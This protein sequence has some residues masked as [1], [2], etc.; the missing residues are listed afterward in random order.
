M[1]TTTYTQTKTYA[2]HIAS[3]VAADL[4]RVQRIYQADR[5][6]D[7]EIN[8]Y[9][10]EI[11]LLLEK[12]YLGTVTYGFKQG[13]NW[14]FAL[15]YKAVDGNLVGEG[16]DPGGIGLEFDVGGAPF[17]SFLLYSQSWE[18][19]GPREREAFEELLPFTRRP[20]EEPRMGNGY[21]AENRSYLSGD[22]GVIRLLIKRY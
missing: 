8:A 13:N 22:L 17:T 15:K 11:A 1:Q 18:R 19:I 10:K 7:E 9:Q 2:Q 3:K 20:G 16:D 4:K 5:P 12:G 21:W 14:I 6:S